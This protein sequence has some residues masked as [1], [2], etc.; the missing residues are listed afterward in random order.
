M[1][2][3]PQCHTEYPSTVRICTRDGTPLDSGPA[4]DPHIG[5]LLDGKY[6][7]DGF[8]SQG[9]MGSVYRATH[10]MLGKTVAVKLIRKDLVTSPEIVRRFQREA[11]A[12][13]ALAHQNI[14]SVHDLGQTADGTVYIAMEFIAGQSL[15]DVIETGGPMAPARIVAILQQVASALSR[16]HRNHIIHRDL[17]PQNIMLTADPDGRERVTLVDFGIAKTFDD[18]ATQLTMSGFAL[19][20]PQ[21]MSPEQASG[22]PVDGRSDLY[23]MGIILYEMLIG[24]VPFTDPSFTAVLIKQMNESPDPPSRRRPD[25]AVHPALET[26]A[27]GCMEKDPNARFQTADEFSAALGH[28]ISADPAAAA[29]PTLLMNAPA[30]PAAAVLS[31][32]VQ[33]NAAAPAPPLKPTV[34]IPPLLTDSPDL[35]VGPTTGGP[36]V[37]PTVGPNVGPR[38]SS[39]TAQ[40]GTRP[41]VAAPA[42]PASQPAAASAPA[43]RRG[44]AAFVVAAIAA[45]V[46][47]GVGAYV[48]IPRFLGGR[49]QPSTPQA[50]YPS[51]TGTPAAADVAPSQPTLA[52]R[53]GVAPPAESQAAIAPSAQRPLAAGGSTPVAGSRNAAV[54]TTAAAPAAQAPAVAAAAQPQPSAPSRPET[55]A[56]YFRCAGAT[57]ICS[58]LRVEVQAA[59]ERAHMPIAANAGRAQVAVSATVE[60]LEQRVTQQFGATFATRT[61]SIGLDGE[62]DGL[63]V[64]MPAP[65]TV[66]FDAQFGRERATEAARLVADDAVT[67]VQEFWAKQAR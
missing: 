34:A 21:Y 17:K 12:A 52:P 14:V 65:R 40:S 4:E 13:S 53:Q 1:P 42:P 16:A 51:P 15:K 62:S 25:V 6:R 64:A 22:K 44:V 10:V 63:A 38:F 7:I 8:I 39:G 41:T 28:A 36:N 23:S 57:E 19:G 56:V 3:C 33:V 54:Q 37:G 24:E 18:S 5:Q 50:A 67:K 47:I 27:L 2:T 46:I 30:T 59:L 20:T 43:P 29:A 55:P 48:A 45:V 35:K 26:I 31:P 11:R 9:G 49:N 60:T 61:Y 32:T 58:P 66:S